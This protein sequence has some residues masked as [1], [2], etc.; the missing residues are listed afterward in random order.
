MDQHGVNKDHFCTI[1]T[2][3]DVSG[4]T[5]AALLNEAKWTVSRLT[6][7]FLEGDPQLRQRVID[8]A[9]E[10]T[11]PDMANLEFLE[12]GSEADIRIAFQQGNGSWSFLG[13]HAQQ[14]PADEPTMNYGWLTPDST[15]DDVRRVV[16]H[17]FGHAVGLIHE[18]QNPEKPIQW[19]RAAVIADLSGPPN[20]WDEQ[21]IENNI[22]KKYNAQDV[23]GTDTDKD[24]IMMYPLPQ[25]WT[26]D[27]FSA[28]LNSDLSDT[29]KEFIR[30]AYP[31]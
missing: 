8:V 15:D 19:N 11:G 18:H 1:R 7:G 30:S 26:L 25:S 22:F 28:G 10:W 21:T 3:Q 14:I 24:S 20:N 29:D 23:T 4:N 16:L 17:E 2:V 9:R 12:D 5:K 6:V 13:T 27:G 31:W